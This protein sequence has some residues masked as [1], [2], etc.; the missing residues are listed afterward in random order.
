MII[1]SIEKERRR[2][3]EEER[4]RRPRYDE[5]GYL[6]G[7]DPAGRPGGRRDGPERGRRRFSFR[8]G[9]ITV[10]V[11]IGLGPGGWS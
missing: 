9:P 8:G 2:M 6:G 1:E 10:S 7:A 3:A 11:S 5:A 4:L